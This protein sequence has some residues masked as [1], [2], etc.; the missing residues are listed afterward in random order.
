MASRRKET[1]KSAGARRKPKPVP[2]AEATASGGKKPL[3]KLNPDFRDDHP[4][5]TIIIAAED[6]RYYKL[7]GDQWLAAATELT[8]AEKGVVA[9]LCEWGTYVAY[10]P[11]EKYVGIGSVCTVVNLKSIQKNQP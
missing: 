2:D 10:L 7:T 6:G 1:T 8:A 11:T 4:R 5:S 3:G 9:E